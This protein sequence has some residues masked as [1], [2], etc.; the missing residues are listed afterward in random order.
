MFFILL[1]LPLLAESSD[2]CE[3]AYS[4]VACLRD[5]AKDVSKKFSVMNLS[6]SRTI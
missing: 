1:S 6:E 3:K 5:H 4:H 2:L